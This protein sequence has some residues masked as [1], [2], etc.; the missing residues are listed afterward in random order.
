MK[1]A[2]ISEQNQESTVSEAKSKKQSHSAFKEDAHSNPGPLVQAT[3]ST[4]FKKA[5][6]KAEKKVRSCHFYIIF[7][8]GLLSRYSLSGLINT[9]SG[10]KFHCCTESGIQFAKS[11]T[12][13][14]GS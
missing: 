7:I 14:S 6:K 11:S 12:N 4:L 13:S 8:V 2:Q 10:L 3:I 5:E 1:G 9:Q